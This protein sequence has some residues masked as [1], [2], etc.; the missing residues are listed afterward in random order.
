M[1]AL[2]AGESALRRGYVAVTQRR[3]RR[4]TQRWLLLAMVGPALIYVIL[5]FAYPLVLD[6]IMSFQK[7]GFAAVIRG[8]GPFVGLGN[9]RYI[10]TDG[11][12]SRAILNTLVFTV[13]S[14]VCQFVIGFAMALYFNQNFT[15]SGFLRRLILIPWVMPLVAVGTMFQ[16]VFQ[17]SNGLANQLLKAV[18]FV[19]N[20]V[21]WLSTGT[22]AVAAIVICNIWAGVPFNA[23]LLYSGLQEVPKELLEAAEVDGA[24]RWRRLFNVVMPSMR[25]VILIVLMLGIVYTVKTFDL[26]VVV[27][28]GGPANESQLLSSWSYTQAFT[29]FQ[30]G[31]GTAI[32]NVLL[33]F[34]LF[35][36]VIYLR[37]SRTSGTTGG[38]L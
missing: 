9:Y 3:R 23:I 13:V 24:G 12:T 10:F 30:F 32:G 25:S 38:V 19:H 36:G 14:I 34:C 29:N 37:L 18:H 2:Q 7:Y 31:Y 11:V 1:T 35:V 20:D 5:F 6:I 16:L 15:G 33:V 4:Q 21:S 27:T 26:V 17:T 8:H 22:L 28:G